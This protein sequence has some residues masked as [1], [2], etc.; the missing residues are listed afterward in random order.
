[1]ISSEMVKPS[2]RI[3]LTYQTRQE[4]SDF[5]RK[6]RELKTC[7]YYV[8]FMRTVMLERNTKHSRAQSRIIPSFI[9]QWYYPRNLASPLNFHEANDVSRELWYFNI[10]IWTPYKRNNRGTGHLLQAKIEFHPR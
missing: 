9:I 1:M 5:M 3:N 7:I 10:F 4:V 6:K 2:L 8:G